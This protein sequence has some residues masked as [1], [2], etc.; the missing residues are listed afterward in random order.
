M[1]VFALVLLLAVTASPSDKYIP[2]IAQGG[3][4][5]TS[6]QVFNTCENPVESF[7]INFYGRDGS[8]KQFTLDGI[9]G[10]TS[11]IYNTVPLDKNGAYAGCTTK[12]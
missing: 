10:T 6:L 5:S 3:G 12:S 4:W 11:R 8:P 2:H 7:E 9:E 1:R